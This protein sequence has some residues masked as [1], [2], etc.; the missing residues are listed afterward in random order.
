M[1]ELLIAPTTPHPVAPATSLPGDL[2]RNPLET[3][4]RRSIRAWALIGWLSLAL[5]L[6]GNAMLGAG[7][8]IPLLLIGG[9]SNIAPTYMA[10]GGRYD[11]VDATMQKR[12]R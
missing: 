8:A 9:M 2:V 11:A 6:I 4:R 12:A 10:L 1:S 3:L 7:I 5:L